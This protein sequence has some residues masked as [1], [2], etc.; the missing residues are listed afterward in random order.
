MTDDT[1]RQREI[2]D[3]VLS[4]FT[5]TEREALYD[6]LTGEHPLSINDVRECL[7]LNRTDAPEGLISE[8]GSRLGTKQVA[9]GRPDPTT[10][11]ARAVV[12]ENSEDKPKP[13]TGGFVRRYRP[14]ISDEA[15][16]RQE[17]EDNAALGPAVRDEHGEP[18]KK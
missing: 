11:V 3:V 6:A 1:S 15:R 7:G 10:Y 17:A 8:A 4:L 14:S 18:Y 2:R 16:A 13:A 5:E 9:A 12:S